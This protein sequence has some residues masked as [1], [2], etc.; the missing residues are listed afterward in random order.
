MT[1]HLITTPFG[2]RTTAAEVLDGVDLTGKRAIVTGAASGIGRETARVLAA[3]G[4][5]V[6]IGVR[7]LAAGAGAA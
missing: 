4:A 6:T 2:A 1:D 3:A 5:E 7:D